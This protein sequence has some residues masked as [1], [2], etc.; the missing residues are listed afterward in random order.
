MPLSVAPDTDG[1]DLVPVAIGCGDDVGRSD[2][3]DVVL[4]GLA[5]EENN[6]ARLSCHCPPTVLAD[7]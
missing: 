3:T 5:A 4:G 7:G 2:A 1:D 6:E